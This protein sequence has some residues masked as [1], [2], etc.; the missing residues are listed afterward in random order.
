[1]L[2]IAFHVSYFA[3]PLPFFRTYYIPSQL[4][5][6]YFGTSN[7]SSVDTMFSLANFPI[8][9]DTVVD[10]CT[11]LVKQ[12]AE[13]SPVGPNT[14]QMAK[15]KDGLRNFVYENCKLF[16]KTNPTQWVYER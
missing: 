10:Q 4:N 15:Q 16:Y 5:L 3:V 1:M 13:E 2:Y 6:L 12:T 7:I 11:S 8:Q 14:L 9:L